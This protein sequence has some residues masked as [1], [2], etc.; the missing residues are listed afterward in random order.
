MLRLEAREM[1]ITTTWTSMGF[2][3]TII[4][5]ICSDAQYPKTSSEVPTNN[6]LISVMLQL[7]T[8]QAKI[9]TQLPR[10]CVSIKAIIYRFKPGP[11]TSQDCA[12]PN[13]ARTWDNKV[14]ACE[15]T[16]TQPSGALRGQWK[17][18]TA[19][20]VIIVVG[21]SKPLLHGA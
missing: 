16:C 3:W 12:Q 17:R 1:G 6:S 19:G 4:N 5:N 8:R 14:P 7:A 9:P 21:V 15:P 11:D 10:S 2:L 18:S 20:V 13:D